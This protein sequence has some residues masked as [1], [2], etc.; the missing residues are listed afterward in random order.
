MEPSLPAPNASPPAGWAQPEQQRLRVVDKDGGGGG[1]TV[2]RPA[3]HISSEEHE[4]TT[5]AVRALANDESVFQRGGRLVHVVRD[6]SR[7]ANVLHAP[8]APR[9]VE[10]SSAGIRDKTT[11]NVRFLKYTKNGAEWIPA[12]PPDWLANAVLARAQWPGVRPLEGV[13][14]TPMLRPDGSILREPGYDTATG[15]FFDPG[16]PITLTLPESPDIE[17][18]QSAAEDLL[19][20]VRDFP[21]KAEAHKSAWLAALLTPFAR[22][23]YA[24]PTPMFLVDANTPAA[25][26]TLLADVVGTV[27]AGRQ[28]PRISLPRNDDDT[29]KLLHSLLMGG[30]PTM[31][32]DNIKGVFDNAAFE[33]LLT[34]DSTKDRALGGNSAPTIPARAV[35]YATGNNA[36]FSSDLIRRTVHIRL[37]S[38]FERPQDRPE[39]SFKHPR[40]LKFVRDERPRLISAVL[41][42]LRAY[43]LAGR[44]KRKVIGWGSY[45]G[46]ERL[47]PQVI[48][49]LGYPDIGETIREFRETSDSDSD[50]TGVFFEALGQLGADSPDNAITCG[51]MVD[52]A[53]DPHRSSRFDDLAE[54]LPTLIRG[55]RTVDANTLGYAL[56]GLHK[57]VDGDWCLRFVGDAAERKTKHAKRWYVLRVTKP[58]GEP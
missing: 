10:L 39:E 13:V 14:E 11:Q 48:A 32:L 50:V 5:A 22:Y 35:W 47:I 19:D 52:A 44:P 6:E 46:W 25:G 31:L 21:F 24:G 18:A 34:G 1:P 36:R 58:E 30:D 4:V 3:I 33:A 42:V 7:L 57:R 40:L 53:K 28:M 56:R 23:A 9:S 45:P 54:V 49:W 2:L 51:A 16:K 15:L 20:V 26:K 55:G 8:N 37:E 27:L 29:R 41:T 12:H 17:N 38:Q 43:Y